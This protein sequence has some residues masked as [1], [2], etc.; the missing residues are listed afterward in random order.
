MMNPRENLFLFEFA[1][2][3]EKIDDSI[4]VEGLAMFKSLFTGFRGYLNINS[5]VRE[6]FVSEFGLPSG[7]IDDFE[8]WIRESS[9]F[10]VIAP[11]DDWLLLNLT[12]TGEKYSTNLG[13]SSRAI[14]V[15]SDKWKLYKKLKGKVNVPK[16]SKN[17]LDGRF[18]IKPRVSCGGEGLSLSYNNVVPDGYIA[19]EYIPGLS[20]SVSFVVGDDINPI[21]VNEQILN[22]F[23]YSGSILP[24]RISPEIA[25]EVI[26][27]ATEAVGHI[28]GLQGYVGVDVVYST[29]PYIIEINARPTTSIVGFD[30][31][32]SSS[33]AEM[34]WKNFM[35]ENF[36]MRVTGRC[37]VYKTSYSGYDKTADRKMYARVKDYV[38]LIEKIEF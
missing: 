36:E 11:E 3:G 2:C 34:I 35:K 12:K 38:I 29:R 25:I 6:E 10:L 27:E 26:D 9:Y 23:Q 28:K 19:Q 18:V 21:S 37:R 32:Y 16:T 14:E 30:F 5:F 31:S 13:S 7:S 1:T 20:L 22:G 33:C 17:P 8:K 4:A 15:T 24:A